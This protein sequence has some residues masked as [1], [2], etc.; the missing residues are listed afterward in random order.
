MVG[1]YMGVIE[2]VGPY[3][4]V[5]EMVGHYMSVIEMVGPYI[6]VTEVGTGTPFC[7]KTWN[8]PK[9]NHQ[10]ENSPLLANLLASLPLARWG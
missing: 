4:G 8:A 1:P 5:I 7:T 2:M 3:M 6:G 9:T 10:S